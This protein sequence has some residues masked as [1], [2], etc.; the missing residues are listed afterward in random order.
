VLKNRMVSTLVAAASAL[1]LLASALPTKAQSTSVVNL[2][3]DG[4]TNITD[5]LQNQ[6]IPAFQKQYPQYTVNFTNTRAS[7]TDPIVARTIAALQTG[8]DPQAEVFDSDPRNFADA[9]KAGLW[10]KPTVADIPNL[11]NVAKA[12]NV[13]DMGASYRG[14][15]VLIAYNSDNV[16]ANE[17]PKTFADLITWIKAHPGKF[18]YCR[19]D[20]G[21]SG[22][23]FV[24]RAL[25]EV[26]GKNPGLFGTTTADQ[27]VID[28][29]YPK[30]FDLLKSINDAIYDHGAYPAGNNPVLKLFA[31][32]EV[33]MISA[34]SDQAI[35]G[36]DLGQLPP[37]TK[38]YQFTDLPMPGGYTQFSIPKNAKNL[39]GAEDFVNYM[40]SVEG[41]TSVVK[42][43]GGFPAIG[44]D[45]L[46][47]A[48]RAQYDS[49]ITDNVPYWP[50]G[51]WDPA[52]IKGWYD[53]VATNLQLTATPVPSATPVG[54]MAATAAQ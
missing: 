44:W 31:S 5:W 12:A 13:T 18:V 11:A 25:Y 27:K 49:V 40:L 46:P 34:W 33:D 48:L 15:Q 7:G 16:P 53:N 43:I 45:K 4:D 19:P 2:Y 30:A 39:K 50:D 21:G 26:S 3:S 17:V 6:I 41:Q 32:G 24:I 22:G 14:S 10:Y 38:L 52:L 47:A 37:S 51:D 36:I 8:S 54:T 42:D 20:Q 35:Q 1:M 29:Y 23:N 9:V 28:Q